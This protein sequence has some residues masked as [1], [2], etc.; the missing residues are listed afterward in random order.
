MLRLS[1]ILVAG[2]LLSGCTNWEELQTLADKQ[3][4]ASRQFNQAVQNLTADPDEDLSS[5]GEAAREVRLTALQADLDQFRP[6]LFQDVLRYDIEKSRVQLGWASLFV[7]APQW[8]WL[9]PGDSGASNKVVFKGG[10]RDSRD[11]SSSGNTSFED[12][13]VLQDKSNAAFDSNR[14]AQG[15]DSQYQT[16]ENQQQGQNFVGDSQ[17]RPEAEVNSD[18]DSGIGLPG[19]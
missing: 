13:Y 6:T 4:E 15:R 7:N 8:A 12:I 9:A 3:L 14:V 17:F 18:F 2:L 1:F 16:G 11:G 5:E 10:N 19:I